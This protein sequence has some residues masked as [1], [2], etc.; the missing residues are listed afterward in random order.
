MRRRLLAVALMLAAVVTV[1]ATFTRTPSAAAGHD[2]A[3]W[4]T[5]PGGFRTNAGV[6]NPSPVDLDVTFT[7]F[8]PVARRLGE[9]TRN[10]PAFTPVQ[11]NNVFASAGVSVD[12]PSAYCVV[13]ADG[14]HALFAYASVIDNRSHDLIFVRGSR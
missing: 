8:D 4:C 10:V 9:V 6:Y 1:F 11:D 3:M 14:I 12:V 5:M 2:G 13:R 7:L